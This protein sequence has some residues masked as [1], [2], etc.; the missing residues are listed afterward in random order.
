[1]KQTK[2]MYS[3]LLRSASGARTFVGSL[4]MNA[5]GGA[6]RVDLLQRCSCTIIICYS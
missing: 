2:T 4:G 5:G 6:G 3:T 1:M